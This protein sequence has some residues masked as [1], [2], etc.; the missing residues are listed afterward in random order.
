MAN[1]EFPSENHSRDRVAVYYGAPE[2]KI[3]CGYHASVLSPETYEHLE[4]IG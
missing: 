2:P 3:L 4:V 1:C